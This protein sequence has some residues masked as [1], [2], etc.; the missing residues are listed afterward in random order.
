MSMSADLLHTKCWDRFLQKGL[1]SKGHEDFQYI[2]LQELEGTDFLQAEDR[3]GSETA[4]IVFVNGF[5]KP[6]LS[7]IEQGLYIMPLSQAFKSYGALLNNRYSKFVLDD[8]DP[9]ALINAAKCKEGAFLYVPPKFV[10]KN[11]VKIISIVDAPEKSWILPRLHIFVGR[12]AE[13][14]FISQSKG[15]GGIYNAVFDFEIDDD[16]KVFLSH[17]DHNSSLKSRFDAFRATLK[18]NSSF[19]SV[20]ITS[21]VKGRSDWHVCLQGEG[22]EASLSGLSYLNGMKEC[23]TNVKIEHREP[24]TRSMQLF[25]VVLE[26]E[27]VSSFQGKIHVKKKAQKTEAYQLNNNLLLSPKATANSKPNLEIFADDVKASHGATVGSLDEEQLFYLR[28]R[29]ISRAVAKK[30]L[31]D[32]F[33]EEVLSKVT[34]HDA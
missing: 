25:K 10:A 4:S 32:G 27:A 8:T 19:T 11:K 2:S 12:S 13:I 30:L 5:F 6:E 21:C 17:D 7:T 22:A 29:G 33:C 15:V 1:P 34:S 14:S 3:E 26:D 24:H 28:A 23:H 18:R 31:I 9:F 20:Q 16:A